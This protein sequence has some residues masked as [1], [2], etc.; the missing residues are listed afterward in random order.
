M[1]AAR[2]GSSLQRGKRGAKQESR[3][4]G[5]CMLVCICLFTYLLG[6]EV[7]VDH[8]R[9]GKHSKARVLDLGE[10]V[11]LALDGVVHLQTTHKCG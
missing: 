5:T 10:G 2:A 11:A 1:Q 9:E 3:A 4:M 8:A 7:L 6:D